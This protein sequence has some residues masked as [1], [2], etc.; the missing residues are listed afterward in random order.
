VR[1]LR[2]IYDFITG[3]S[4]AAPVALAVGISVARASPPGSRAG[5]LA[6]FVAISLAAATFERVR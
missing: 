3:G 4:I 6:A 1:V 5:I 2:R